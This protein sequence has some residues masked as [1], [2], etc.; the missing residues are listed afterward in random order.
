MCW[1]CENAE[2]GWFH[3]NFATLID[4]TWAWYSLAIFTNPHNAYIKLTPL[5][6]HCFQENNCTLTLV[7]ALKRQ[8]IE[9]VYAVRSCPT[10]KH[11]FSNHLS[12]LV[13]H[14]IAGSLFSKRIFMK[15]EKI[16]FYFPKRTLGLLSSKWRHHL[17]SYGNSCTAWK[18]KIIVRKKTRYGYC[19]NDALMAF[20]LETTIGPYVLTLFDS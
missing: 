9:N 7:T 11:S 8:L 2:L 10:K 5:L 6:C 20:I 16:Y 1:R 15:K 12:A 3:L 19:L 14:L 13:L 4:L 18:K 17:T